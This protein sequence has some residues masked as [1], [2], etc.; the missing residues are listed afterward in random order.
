MK[1]KIITLTAVLLILAGGL[2]SCKDK[3]R[4]STDI[5]G[6]WK[7]KD[8]CLSGELTDI[9]SPRLYS[10]ILVTIPETT[11]G[12]IISNTSYDDTIW[13][14]F[15]IK[16]RKQIHMS[17]DNEAQYVKNELMIW[18]KQGVDAEAFA[19]NSDLGITPKEL[20]ASSWNVWLFETDGTRSLDELINILSQDPNVS[21]VQKNHTNITLRDV[22][23]QFFIKNML[24]TVMF[25]ISNNE[26]IFLDS[27]N[28]QIIIFNRLK[29]I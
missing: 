19:A 15:E 11:S 10:E 7:V 2:T 13:F 12:R 20:L 24:N 18:F 23:M 27:L 22:R 17:W 8:L 26:L 28:N 4:L 14:T 16:E 5:S 9:S 1:T 29:K 3:E 6:T 21:F 25:D